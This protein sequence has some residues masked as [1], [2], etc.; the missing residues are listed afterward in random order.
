[1]ARSA[2]YVLTRYRELLL[3]GFA[4]VREGKGVGVPVW[5]GVGVRVGVSL[6]RRVQ[7]GRWVR[8]GVGLSVAGIGVGFPVGKDRPTGVDSGRIAFPSLN[9]KKSRMNT[10]NSR[11]AAGRRGLRLVGRLA[12]CLPC[13]ERTPG[14]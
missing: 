8:V 12:I 10:T 4:G 14:D 9:A 2:L 11:K 3:R 6:G 1:M 7:V 13:R 5:V